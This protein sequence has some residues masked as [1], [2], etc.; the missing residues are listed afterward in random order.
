M[1]SPESSLE[2]SPLLSLP[3]LSEV[4][5]TPPPVCLSHCRRYR[6]Y[7]FPCRRTPPAR[8]S[9]L[10]TAIST[11]ASLRA[12]FSFLSFLYVSLQ[13]EAIAKTPPLKA[14]DLSSTSCSACS[15]RKCCRLRLLWMR[16]ARCTRRRRCPPGTSRG[17][18]S[19]CGLSYRR[20]Y[21]LSP[22]RDSTPSRCR[23]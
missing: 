3:S 15:R 12:S 16:A 7:S 2:S 23:R 14:A 8:K 10:R 21:P 19:G 11:R 22:R 1:P 4:S 9:L 5:S 17:R 18:G 20:V 6:R 13:P